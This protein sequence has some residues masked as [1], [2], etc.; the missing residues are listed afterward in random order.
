MDDLKKLQPFHLDVLKEIGN[1]GAGNAATSLSLLLNKTIDMSVPD[2]RVV[3]LQEIPDQVG[4]ADT[5]VAAIFLRIEGEAPGS[6]YFIA[7]IAD[8]E[9]MIRRLIGN[10]HFQL[11][12]PPFDEMGISAFLEVGNI[13]AGSYLS[14]FSD[15]TQ[16][17]LQPSVPG[18]SIDM[19][20]AILSYGLIP[21]SEV[22]DFAIVIDTEIV[23]VDEESEK[24]SGH[25][26]LLPDPGSFQTIFKALG[27]EIDE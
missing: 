7:N 12:S 16:L 20:G 24:V 8:I 17:D 13:L 26:F 23:E 10:D 4:G 6:M 18:V 3:S 14:S 1:I 9:K 11:V 22:G 15:F 2:V 21:I 19:A 25:F 5:E 27:V